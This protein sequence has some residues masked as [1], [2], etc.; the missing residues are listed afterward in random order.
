[1]VPSPHTLEGGQKADLTAAKLA[2]ALS[3]CRQRGARLTAMR[4]RL[5]EVL[6]QAGHPLGAYDVKPLLETAMGRRLAPPTV[7]RA[8][9]FLLNQGLIARIE[10]RSAFVPRIHP[11]DPHPCAF[12]VC[13]Q[14][15]DATEVENAALDSL[16][17]DDAASLGFHVDRTVVE[18]EGTCVRCLPVVQNQPV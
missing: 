6:L 9:T 16:I 1:M 10:S 7:Y 4:W 8:L 15:G 11:E 5:L 18:L 17:A 2:V 14:C 12:F 3:L 13:A